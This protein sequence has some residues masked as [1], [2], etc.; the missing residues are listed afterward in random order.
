MARSEQRLLQIECGQRIEQV[1]AFKFTEPP[2]CQMPMH[3]F[4]SVKVKIEFNDLDR[5]ACTSAVLHA[6]QNNSPSAPESATARGTHNQTHFSHQD[7][8]TALKNPQHHTM[9]TTTGPA[10]YYIIHGSG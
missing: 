6:R 7:N 8:H 3:A 9:Q 1:E 2:S 10:H 5:M 4:R